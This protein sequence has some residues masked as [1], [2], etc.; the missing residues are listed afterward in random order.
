MLMT[1][2]YKTNLFACIFLVLFAVAELAAAQDQSDVR[3][4]VVSEAMDAGGYTYI[5]CLEN[6]AEIWVATMRVSLRIGEKISFY[7]TPPMVNF[8]SKDLDRT[9]SRVMFVT[10]VARN[11]DLPSKKIP[12]ETYQ[13]TQGYSKA[14]SY[15][16]ERLY[17]GS[18]ENGA[19]VFSDD[20]SKAP[21]SASVQRKS[22]KVQNA[23]MLEN[24]SVTE[25]KLIL[26]QEKALN[27]YC[28]FDLSSLKS[29][30]TA[31]FWP[32]FKEGLDKEGRSNAASFLRN[33][34]FTDFRVDTIKQH[35]EKSTLD[36]MSYL[37]AD[38][39]FV[40]GRVV[41]KEGGEEDLTCKGSFIKEKA[42]WKYIDIFCGVGRHM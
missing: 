15:E 12:Q 20:P 30:T 11:G 10:G 16:E 37:L 21:K 3:S 17:T 5:R 41:D 28:S 2:V 1:A 34:C 4:C 38:M 40:A 26:M 6:R 8:R 14:P 24:F 31:K 36:G 18:D 19:L 35:N 29:I 27:A 13:K 22:R 25:R 7:D 39:D 42:G 23:T 33:F 9:F 32:T